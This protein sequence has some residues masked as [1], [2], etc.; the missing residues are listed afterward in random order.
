MPRTVIGTLVRHQTVAVVA[1]L[2]FAS[3]LTR[4]L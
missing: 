1:A 3:T 4:G 2:A